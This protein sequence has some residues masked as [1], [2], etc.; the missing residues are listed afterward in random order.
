MA[1]NVLTAAKQ[2]LIGSLVQ[3]ELLETASLVGV[4]TNYSNLAV[5]G[6][7]QVS[8]PKLTSFTVADRAFGAQGSENAA[9]TAAVDDIALDKNKYILFGYDAADEMQSTIDYKIE[10]IRRASQA[11]GRQINSDIITEIEAVGGLSVNGASPADITASNILDMREF[12]MANFANMATARF[13]IA[14][15]QEKVLL[16][17]PEF[18][19][20]EYRGVGPAPVMNGVIGSVYGVPVVLNQQL[21]AQ[22]AFMIAPEG[23]GFAFQRNPAVGEDTDLRYGVN[24]MQVAVDCTYGVGGLQLGEGTAASGKSPLVALLTD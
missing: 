24:G 5:K 9:L 4:C 2:D 22:Q 1:A 16:S 19:R 3:R 15:D 13:V 12:L 6:A 8:I 14:A 11:H 7:K 23:M 20:Y 21:K 10:A 18:S 17:L